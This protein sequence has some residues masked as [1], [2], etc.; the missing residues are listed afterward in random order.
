MDFLDQF[1]FK[2]PAK[3][4]QNSKSNPVSKPSS[5]DSDLKEI[6]PR[7]KLVKKNNDMQEE[8]NPIQIQPS[9]K[10]FEMEFKKQG[11]NSV[12]KDEESKNN[13]QEKITKK[14]KT[15]EILRQESMNNSEITQEVFEVGD[16]IINKDIIMISSWNVA[17][18][19]RIL[20]HKTLQE[21]ILKSNP[22]ILCLNEIKTD[23]ERIEKE[24][25][26]SW[27]P[28]EYTPFFNCCKTSKGYAGTAFIT[29][30]KPITVKYGMGIPKHDLEG[31]VIT[32]EFQNFFL[33]CCYVPNAGEKLA[34][35]S[36][37]TQEWD[38]DFRNYVSN[39]KSIKNVVICGDLNVAHE[40]IDLY[41][42]KGHD[43]TPCFTP[44]ERQGF[45]NLIK[46]G[47]IDT[48]RYLYRYEKQFSFYSF[49]FNARETNRGWR[50]DY[51]LVN[52][53]S[54]GAVED[55]TINTQVIGSDHHPVELIYHP[56]G[57]RKS[58]E[59]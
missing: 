59:D 37:R 28:K 6:K 43:K 54:I 7:E 9:L 47:F 21:Y 56:N 33:V 44:Q 52:S 34:R 36:Y 48:F 50:L 15:V 16:G 11:K 51:F 46:S 32:A 5:Q 19:K 27:I 2:R 38:V 57:P 39:L 25:L 14:R 8:S 35:L 18:L 17:G 53:E 31:R 4:N 20:G 22:D 1:S 24:D 40:E 58:G 29:K 3:N 13:N 42:P 30:H 41:D 10:A 26:A 45:S 49:R 55:L 12:N 23:D